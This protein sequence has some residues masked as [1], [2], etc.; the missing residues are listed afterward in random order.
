VTT[1]RLFADRRHGIDRRAEPRRERR[2]TLERRAH[3]QRN[4]SVESP[5]EHLRNALQ[6]LGAL[7]FIDEPMLDGVV[8]RLQRALELLEQQH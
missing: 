6:M 3:P 2:S 7:H 4:P 5:G 1:T 8:T